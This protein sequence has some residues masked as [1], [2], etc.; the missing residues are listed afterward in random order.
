VT[1]TDVDA[2]ALIVDGVSHRFISAGRQR[3][4]LSVPRGSVHAVV[5]PS[6][7]GKT[8][9]FRTIRGLETPDHGAV[10]IGSLRIDTADRP[11]R[12]ALRLRAVGAVQQSPDLL[13]ELNAVEN[14]ELPLL[15]ERGTRSDARERALEML[16]IVGLAGLAERDVFTLSGGERQR[17]SVAR[18]LIRPELTL[19]LAD[20]PTASLDRDNAVKVFRALER[21]AR[22]RHVGCLLATHDLH[23]ADLCQEVHAI[24]DPA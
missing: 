19:I 22:E 17:V 21:A 5:G 18:A 13:P 3:V 7:S 2:D 15:F 10:R 8:T 4:S 20:E 24:D 6:G 1:R 14:V 11:G 12:A 9:L 16:E 23:I